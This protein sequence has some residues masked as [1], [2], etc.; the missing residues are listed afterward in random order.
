MNDKTFAIEYLEK[1]LSEEEAE[2]KIKLER[3]RS[4]LKYLWVQALHSFPQ[5]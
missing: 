1:C 2:E 5:F 4:K 3:K